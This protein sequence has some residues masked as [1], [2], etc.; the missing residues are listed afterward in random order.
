MEKKT[1]KLY[2]G[3]VT[4]IIKK[5]AL[6]EGSFTRPSKFSSNDQNVLHVFPNVIDFC[7]FKLKEVIRIVSSPKYLRRGRLEFNVRLDDIKKTL[8]D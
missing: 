6:Y 1:P 5:G 7:N 3:K 8:I 2:F 4:K